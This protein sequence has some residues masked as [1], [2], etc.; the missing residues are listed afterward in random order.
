MTDKQPITKIKIPNLLTIRQFCEKYP[1]FS[2]GAMRSYIF[3]ADFNGLTKSKAI[4]RIGRKILIDIEAFFGWIE[5]KTR[6]VQ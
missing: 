2:S 6:E 3:N 1:A 5:T 4:K